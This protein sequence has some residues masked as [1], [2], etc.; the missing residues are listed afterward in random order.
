MSLGNIAHLTELELGMKLEP[1]RLTQAPIQPLSTVKQLTLV[2]Y[3]YKEKADTVALFRFISSTFPSLV[4]Y[5]IE[6]GLSDVSSQ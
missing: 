3:G 1:A 5:S 2:W 6:N 4:K